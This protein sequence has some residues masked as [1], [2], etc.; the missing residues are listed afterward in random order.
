MSRLNQSPIGA[1][2]V[3]TAFVDCPREIGRRVRTGDLPQVRT[4]STTRSSTCCSCAAWMH[5]DETLATPWSWWL[6]VSLSCSYTT[7]AM[8]CSFKSMFD[9]GSSAGECWHKYVIAECSQEVALMFGISETDELDAKSPAVTMPR[10]APIVAPA[11]RITARTF[12]VLW[13]KFPRLFVLVALAGL[14]WCEK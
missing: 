7:S 2:V 12:G 4:H 13:K 5:A 1:A 14:T 10:S 8:L 6:C 9:I 3:T 11:A